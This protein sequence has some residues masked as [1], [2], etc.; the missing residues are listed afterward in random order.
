MLLRT[1][2]MRRTFGAN[3]NREKPLLASLTHPFVRRRA[4]VI[5][6]AL[7]AGLMTRVQPPFAQAACVVPMEIGPATQVTTAPLQAFN[8]RLAW[9]GTEY[10]VVWVDDRSGSFQVYFA[11]LDAGGARLGDDRQVTQAASLNG[12]TTRLAWNGSGYGVVWAAGI[13]PALFF[14]RLDATGAVVD[15]EA[16]EVQVTGQ[17]FHLPS[18]SLV[19]NGDGYGLAWEDTRDGNFEIYL[20]RLDANGTRIGVDTR[21]TF[22]PIASI[23]PTLVW[24]GSEYGLVWNETNNLEDHVHFTR[25]SPAGVPLGP[26]GPVTSGPGNVSAPGLAWD[27]AGY[28][29]AWTRY[30]EEG[31]D[32]YFRHLDAAGTPD[33]DEVGAST[34]PSTQVLWSIAWSGEHFGLAWYD[35]RFGDPEIFFRLVG[36]PGRTI[37]PE[38]RLTR[39]PRWSYVPSLVWA[40][41]RFGVAWIDGSEVPESS[42]AIHFTRVGCRPGERAP[43]AGGGP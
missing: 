27:G 3:A 38:V 15:P 21:V 33:G 39:N 31:A 30:S 6:S 34:N 43:D 2:R 32:V 26:G 20:S 41:D 10:G 16:P 1:S 25:I 23:Q 9:T 12:D 4:F 28:G 13:G 24:T 35:H 11:R 36:A 40:E 7:L 14:G 42:T 8:P 5:A 18:A 37:G 19:W 22:S 29:L 17:M